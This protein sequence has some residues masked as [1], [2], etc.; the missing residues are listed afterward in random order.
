[1]K[2]TINNIDWKVYFYKEEAHE[3]A[4]GFCKNVSG[5][6]H[7]RKDMP[8]YMVK[9]TIMHEVVHAYLWSH[10][11]VK[12]DEDATL[13]FSEEQVC[14]FI[15]MNYVELTKLADKI[16]MYYLEHYENNV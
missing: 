10:G 9:T 4:L 2:V 12:P 8:S 5:E 16:Y 7:I 15:G 1:M 13:L 11:F 14:D 6:I 3:G